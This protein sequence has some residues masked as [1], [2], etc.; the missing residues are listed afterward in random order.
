MRTPCFYARQ[1]CGEHQPVDTDSPGSVST[2]GCFPQK[3]FFDYL[4]PTGD[5]L[6]DRLN[7]RLVGLVMAIPGATQDGC[8]PNGRSV[9]TSTPPRSGDQAEPGDHGFAIGATA[10]GPSTLGMEKHS[11]FA[12]R[13][14][15]TH[16]RPREQME[17]K[18]PRDS[19]RGRPGGANSVL[20]PLPPCLK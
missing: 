13:G 16:R 14:G 7:F 8:H 12:I 9:V 20:T 11:C 4:S 2:G 17:G 6:P 1:Q 18:R 15:G 3:L 10:I 19:P 5:P